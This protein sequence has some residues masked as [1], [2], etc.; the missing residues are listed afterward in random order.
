MS[1]L[2]GDKRSKNLLEHS[3]SDLLFPTIH[4]LLKQSRCVHRKH[5]L[6]PFCNYPQTY[7]TL[8]SG[9][10]TEIY[11]E[12]RMGST[13]F[14]CLLMVEWLANYSYLF[15]IWKKLKTIQTFH[16]V[17]KTDSPPPHYRENKLLAHGGYKVYSCWLP[18]NN[19]S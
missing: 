8:G 15:V 4:L 10:T 19:S 7:N 6:I 18:F 16:T 1:P 9:C 5:I 12:K 17:L 11:G 14:R 13:K 3:I 2:E